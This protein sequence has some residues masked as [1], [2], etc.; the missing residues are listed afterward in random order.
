[1]KKLLLLFILCSSIAHSQWKYK[2]VDN[3]FDGP[4]RIAY[5]DDNNDVMLKLE[6]LDGE[7]AF[8]LQGKYIC[9]EEVLV[10]LAFLING[11]YSRYTFTGAVNKDHDCL[12]FTWDLIGSVA[13]QDFRDCKQLNVRINDTTCDSSIYSFNMS[14]SNLALKYVSKQ[15]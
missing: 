5:T 9:D 13:D 2:T 4:Y 7:I 10:D 11:E 14:G 6:N 8:Y 12:F 1:M 3:G 15:E